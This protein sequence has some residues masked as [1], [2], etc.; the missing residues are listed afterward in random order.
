M[1][2]FF[3][4]QEESQNQ[5]LAC[6]GNCISCK[7]N[8]TCDTCVNGFHVKDDVCVS[9]DCA[10]GTYWNNDDEKCDDCMLGCLICKDADSCEF[11]IDPVEKCQKSSFWDENTTSC[12]SCGVAYCSDCS[13]VNVC[14]SCYQGYDLIAENNCTAKTG[15]EAPCGDGFFRDSDSKCQ[16]CLG[17]CKQCTNST[18]CLECFSSS[19]I[20]WTFNGDSCGFECALDCKEGENGCYACNDTTKICEA[21]QK[22]YKYSG[23]HYECEH[24]ESGDMCQTDQGHNYFWDNSTSKCEQCDQDAHCLA[25]DYLSTN[26]TTCQEGYTHKLVDGTTDTWQCT[27]SAEELVLGFASSLV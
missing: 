3:Y 11:C 9:D 27:T 22:G 26:C 10:D 21:C 24:M 19:L 7:D 8:T 23:F 13:E 20:S 25:C 18:S 6:I 2:G 17:R 14:T 1:P 5:C 12:T 15:D 16:K 4:E